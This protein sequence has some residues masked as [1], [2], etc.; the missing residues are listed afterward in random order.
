MRRFLLSLLLFVV[1]GPGF[2]STILV[3][4][5]SISAGYGLENPDLGWVGLMGEKLK[6]RRSG[7]AVVNASISGETS[8][9]GIARIDS[10]LSRHKPAIL[11]LE[12][13][14]ND[15]LRGLSPARMQANLG[16]IIMRAKA[17]GARV[18][19]LGMRI[20]PNYG[21]RYAE[22]F[23]GVYPALARQQGATLVPFL[24]EG[25]GGRDHLMQ[26]DGLHPNGEAQPILLQR[27]W[28]KLEPM[29]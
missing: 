14:A 1:P 15:G 7:V 4:G 3:L 29:L 24:M 2:G 28:E 13:G 12:L 19:L 16:E 21:K 27:V 23:S 9:G 10:L 18:L 11:I 5:D 26:G 17:A 22:M 25:V 8:F 6:K 20:P